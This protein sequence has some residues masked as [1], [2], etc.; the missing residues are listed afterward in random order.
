M[1]VRTAALAVAIALAVS[2]STYA[3]INAG[4]GASEA[5]HNQQAL[6][7]ALYT[8]LDRSSRLIPGYVD[9]GTITSAQGVQALADNAAAKRDIVRPSC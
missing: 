3:I 1:R 5:C 2:S 6:V 4:E 8:I 7:D 9:S